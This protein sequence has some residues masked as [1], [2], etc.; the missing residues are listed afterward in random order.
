MVD[1]KV[2]AAIVVA[3]AILTLIFSARSLEASDLM[4]EAAEDFL[5]NFEFS[6]DGLFVDL[7][8]EAILEAI[9]QVLSLCWRSSLPTISNSAG[10]RKWQACSL[11]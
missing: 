4:H 10:S 1:K 8:L 3:P 2:V 6:T 11:G 5:S 7:S 9:D